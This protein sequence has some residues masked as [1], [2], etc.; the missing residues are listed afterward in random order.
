MGVPTIIISPRSEGRVKNKSNPT[1]VSCDG[2]SAFARHPRTCVRAKKGPELARH[3]SVM[4][5]AVL[6]SCAIFLLVAVG[7]LGDIRLLVRGQDWSCKE[8]GVNVLVLTEALDADGEVAKGFA[9][10]DS[11]HA[12]NRLADYLNAVPEGRTVSL[13]I[14]QLHIIHHDV[15]GCS[16][17]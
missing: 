13:C 7:G 12:A 11:F 8:A 9:T 4:Y 15:Q 3:L 17:V 2:S 1:L 5:C 14:W 6:V 10:H 16:G